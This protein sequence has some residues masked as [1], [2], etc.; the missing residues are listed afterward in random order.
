[1]GRTESSAVRRV[2]EVGGG[3]G[4]YVVR[5]G[6]EFRKQT[7][8]GRRSFREREV[9]NR[10]VGSLESTPQVTGVLELI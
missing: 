9:R 10:R 4:P 2:P 7:R 6:I 3:Q 8:D 1:M 5:G